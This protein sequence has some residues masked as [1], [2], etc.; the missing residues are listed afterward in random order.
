MVWGMALVLISCGED[1]EPVDTID[2]ETG[3]EDLDVSLEALHLEDGEERIFVMPAPLQVATALNLHGVEYNRDIVIDPPFE[4]SNLPKFIKA[5]NMGAHVIDLG[6]CSIYGEGE[7]AVALLQALRAMGDDLGVDGYNEDIVNRFELNQ[8]DADSLSYLILEGYEMAHEYIRQNKREEMG[9]VVLAG[10]WM[11][12]LYL[13]CQYPELENNERFYTLLAQQKYYL[14]NLI[15]LM[16]RFEEEEVQDIVY[17]LKKLYVLFDGLD[18]TADM[19]Q[20]NDL[21]IPAD[22]SAI[23]DQIRAEVTDFRNAYVT[24]TT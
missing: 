1:S 2:L 22:F 7:S 8:D 10:S 5:F 24:M 20:E 11:E 15:I 21:E 18:T 12:G 13:T 9:L 23:M 16:S 3:V 14:E 6:Y 17:R 4:N 19:T